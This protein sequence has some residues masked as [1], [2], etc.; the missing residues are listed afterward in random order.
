MS[1]ASG[2]TE[3][4]VRYVETDKMGVAHH[5]SFL[6]WLEVARTDLM[7]GSGMTY[8]DLEAQGFFLPVLEVSCRYRRP[9]HYDD[10]LS[11]HTEG[12]R[13]GRARLRFDYVVSRG[14]ERIA[15][16]FSIHA[17]TDAEG[18]PRRL[19]P[20]LLRMFEAENDR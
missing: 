20:D 13:I 14:D 1:P 18:V 12:R 5:S 17:A 9:A 3:L 16:A 8:R 15:E 6:A 10:Q 11:I 4:R 7:R 19:P 2:R